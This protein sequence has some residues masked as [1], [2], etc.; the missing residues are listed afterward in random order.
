MGSLEDEILVQMVHDFMEYS[1]SPAR[2]L[3]SSSSNCPPLNNQTQYF[4]LLDILGRGTQYEAEVLKSILN[5]MRN[6][7]NTEK[8]TDMKKWLLLKLKMDGYNASLCQTSW[9]TSLGCTAGDYEYIEIIREPM[10]L[11]VDIDFQ[12]QFELARPTASYKQLTDT[13]PTIYVGTEAKLIKII[14][15]LCSAAKQSLK[16]RGLHL[17]PWRTTT[18]M[19]S[20]WLASSLKKDLNNADNEVKSIGVHCFSNWAP[21]IVKPKRRNLG[22]GSGLSSQFSNMRINCC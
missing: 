17:P 5:Y 9:V 18:Y 21:P 15:L 10:R 7:R 1:E 22:N 2:P 12:S 3:F 16:D 8:T 11:V 14:S 4:T 6:K 20:K 19:Q 13:L